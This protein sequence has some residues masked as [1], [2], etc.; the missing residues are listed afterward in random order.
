[1]FLRPILIRAYPGLPT[2][3]VIFA[4]LRQPQCFYLMAADALYHVSQGTGSHRDVGTSGI[5][6]VVTCGLD[7]ST[8]NTM[9][10]GLM[11]DGLVV[12]M[13]LGVTSVIAVPAFHLDLPHSCNV[14]QLV[15]N[16]GPNIVPETELLVLTD[17]FL[18]RYHIISEQIISQL[19]ISEMGVSSIACN[20]TGL[21]FFNSRNGLVCSTQ[22]HWLFRRRS[23]FSRFQSFSSVLR[24]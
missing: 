13:T 9:R 5:L 7:S 6:N 24:C 15:W 11:T 20:A 21:V 12:A 4:D 23:R 8:T 10:F 17:L 2:A 18:Y 22:P 19:F 1:M 14:L 16:R 3:R